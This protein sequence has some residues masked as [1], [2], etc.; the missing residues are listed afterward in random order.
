MWCTNYKTYIAPISFK[1]I[2]LNGAPSTGIG[3]T[4]SLGSMQS[5]STLIRWKG[6]LGRIS[7]S[8]KVSFQ[9]GDGVKLCYLMTYN[10]LVYGSSCEMI[11]LSSN[12]LYFCNPMSFAFLPLSPTS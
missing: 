5:S 3:Q 9:N 1:R 8:K 7:E 4:H 11:R 10:V 6:N 2:K 12:A